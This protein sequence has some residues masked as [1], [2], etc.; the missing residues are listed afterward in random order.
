M[1][2]EAKNPEQSI[3][4]PFKE[5]ISDKYLLMLKK[6]FG[7]TKSAINSLRKCYMEKNKLV[8]LEHDDLGHSLTLQSIEEHIIKKLKKVYINRKADLLP[9]YPI[10][11][12]HIEGLHTMCI[13]ASGSGKTKLIT[14]ICSQP[15][16]DKATFW[17]LSPTAEKDHVIQ[18]FIKSKPK[19]KI[20]IIDLDLIEK[21]R[22]VLS[23]KDVIPYSSKSSPLVIIFDDLENLSGDLR[24]SGAYSLKYTLFNFI[25]Q[26]MKRGRHH[27]LVSFYIGH[28][29][30]IGTHARDI[31]SQASRIIFLHKM[32]NPF[33]LKKYL[34]S[35]M[36]F[37]KKFIDEIFDLHK[38]SR[39]LMIQQSSPNMIVSQ[40]CVQLF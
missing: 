37:T 1:V 20:R 28:N 7:I 38:D 18:N 29:S 27:S 12:S 3:E 22:K 39:Y 25:G 2:P 15:S 34:G 11:R 23:I 19:N 24:K 40:K 9:Y 10:D 4:D 6:K 13:G 32:G 26:V 21:E 17:I 5:F 33:P 36:G 8:C 16:F 31:R 30:R 14:S 35:E